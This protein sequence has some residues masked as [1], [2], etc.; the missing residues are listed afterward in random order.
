MA[1]LDYH[2]F[3][4]V[5]W[6]LYVYC[7]TFSFDVNWLFYDSVNVDGLLNFFLDIDI[8]NDFLFNDSINWNLFFNNLF[9]INRL[10]NLFFD[11]SI[12]INRD[13]L[14]NNSLIIDRDFA[15]DVLLNI[16]RLFNLLDVLNSGLRRLDLND[17][18]IPNRLDLHLLV[19]HVIG[20][21]LRVD[22]GRARR[23]E[24]HLSWR[25]HGVHC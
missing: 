18:L 2:L 20:S 4:Y 3:F 13:L 15:V 25:W 14:F 6:L 10:F 22:V 16:D 12:I 11:N 8:L 19:L 7:F 24:L 23:L 1:V 17:L 9:I 21:G 5:H